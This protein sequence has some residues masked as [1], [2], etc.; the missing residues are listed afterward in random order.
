M[1][2][3]KEDS[4]MTTRE[5]K[6]MAKDAM[7]RIQE[8]GIKVI[9]A[10][11]LQQFLEI[12]DTPTHRI[13]DYFSETWKIGDCPGSL[14]VPPLKKVARKSTSTPTVAALRKAT[15]RRVGEILGDLDS[16]D[17]LVAAAI[18]FMQSEP[19]TEQEIKSW[20]THDRARIFKAWNAIIAVRYNLNKREMKLIA[21]QVRDQLANTPLT[22]AD[23]K[24][25]IRRGIA[26]G[27][28]TAN[29]DGS[30]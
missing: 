3:D 6:K 8:A 19:L 1:V 12:G 24:A 10:I 9:T 29:R 30:L 23:I 11:Q 20:I 25:A 26:G 15:L 17:T 2:T 28:N 16:P 22:R 18:R 13:F 5:I 7:H 14:I 21:D 27:D 4:K